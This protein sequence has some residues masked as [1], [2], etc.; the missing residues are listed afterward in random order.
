MV[1]I[2]KSGTI[3]GPQQNRFDDKVGSAALCT[4]LARFDLPRELLLS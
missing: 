4:H 1:L 3:P 2:E